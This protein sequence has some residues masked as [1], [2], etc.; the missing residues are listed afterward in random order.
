MK[1]KKLTKQV[2][3]II[4]DNWPAHPS[5]VCRSLDMDCNVS[6]ISKIKYHFKK[7]EHENL[8]RTKKIDRALVAWPTEIERLRIMHEFM[9]DV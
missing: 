9:K 3:K 4:Q 6:N 2:Y 7:L 1:G 5:F 8:I